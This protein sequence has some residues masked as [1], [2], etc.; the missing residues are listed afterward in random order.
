MTRPQG[1]PP[2]WQEQLYEAVWDAADGFY[3][4]R[5]DHA[6]AAVELIS[7]WLDVPFKPQEYMP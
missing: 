1:F 4:E 7:E 6:N 3:D 5:T 2:D